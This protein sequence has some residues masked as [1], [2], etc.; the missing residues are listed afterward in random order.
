MIAT[1]KQFQDRPVISASQAESIKKILKTISAPKTHISRTPE[2]TGSQGFHQHGPGA[3]LKG[4][5]GNLDDKGPYLKVEK[6][7]FTSTFQIKCCSRGKATT[8]LRMQK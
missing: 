5:I 7:V 3:E 1:L 4:A 2:R 6:G 8:F